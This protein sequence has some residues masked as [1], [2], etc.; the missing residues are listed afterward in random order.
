MNIL[1]EYLLYLENENILEDEGLEDIDEFIDAGV[2]SIPAILAGAAIAGTGMSAAKMVAD[3][4]KAKT[5][6]KI[7]S[8]IKDPEERKIAYVR[9]Y[10]GG[11]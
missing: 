6:I 10:Q 7:A 5:C 9:C 2:V 8:S 3:K 4:K 11:H 1:E